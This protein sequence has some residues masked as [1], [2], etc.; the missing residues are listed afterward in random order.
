LKLSRVNGRKKEEKRKARVKNKERKQRMGY[1]GVYDSAKID[2]PRSIGPDLSF[3]LLWI[4]LRKCIIAR[5]QC[6]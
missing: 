4:S 6:G 3:L 1:S 5:P 2:H